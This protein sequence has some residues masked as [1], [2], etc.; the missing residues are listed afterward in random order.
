[1]FNHHHGV[2]LIDQPLQHDQQLTN[3]LKMQARGW[4]I[5]NVQ[6]AACCTTAELLS[7]FHSLSLP[8]RQGGG[9][10]P[11]FDIAQ[12]DIHQHLQL[13]MNVG[14][15]AEEIGGLLNRHGQHVGDRFVAVQ[16]FQGFAV[17]AFAVALIAIDIH[18]GQEVHFDFQQS[19]ALTGLTAPPLNIEGKT[20]RQIAARL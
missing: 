1:M 18:I 12:A 13:F 20:A 16:H 5:Q 15:R 17:V 4:L 11:Q 14:N 10:L 19:I 3:I 7:Q 2:A 9:R 6:G 8:P